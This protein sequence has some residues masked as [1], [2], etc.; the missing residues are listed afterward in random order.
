MKAMY[1]YDEEADALYILVA[2]EDEASIHE[3]VELRDDLHVDLDERGQLVGVE[4]LSPSGS[5][6]LTLVKQRFGVELRVPFSFAAA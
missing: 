1:T 3:T 2:N 4:V 5:V 6:D